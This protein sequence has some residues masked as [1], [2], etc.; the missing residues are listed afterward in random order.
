MVILFT[1]CYYMFNYKDQWD[2]GL[3]TCY[4]MLYNS[5]AKLLSKNL[6]KL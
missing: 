4:T 1:E 6:F 2:P 3:F 5:K